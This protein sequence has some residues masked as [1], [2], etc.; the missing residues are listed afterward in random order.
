MTD[1]PA[2]SSPGSVAPGVSRRRVLPGL[3]QVLL[4]SLV[5]LGAAVTGLGVQ[6]AG[7]ALPGWQQAVL[8]GLALVTAL[9]PESLS[10]LLML[11]VA[12][13]A[14]STAPSP[15]SP[16]VLVVAAGMV[17]A[18]VAAL[19]AAQGPA[20]TAVDAVQ[21]RLWATRALALWV[22]SAGVWALV[23]VLDGGPTHRWAYAAGLAALIAL[24][25]AGT[26]V[27]S[28]RPGASSSA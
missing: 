17:L 21:V 1:V 3:G 10:G 12:A 28:R 4:R 5:V 23:K 19:V 27:L 16:L 7:A 25:V 18:H 13:Y 11:A 6:L 15:S 9:R 14:W 22:A 24:T 20:R 26:A 8:L 2:G